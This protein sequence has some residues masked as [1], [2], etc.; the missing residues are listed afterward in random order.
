MRYKQLLALGL[1]VVMLMGTGCQSAGTEAPASTET[2]VVQE[3][4]SEALET[5]NEETSVETATETTGAESVE[6]EVVEPEEPEVLE[7]RYVK[8]KKISIHAAP[9]EESEILGELTARTE[10]EIAEEQSDESGAVKWLRLG[11]SVDPE[12]ASWIPADGVVEHKYDLMYTNY[13][14]VDYGAVREIPDYRNNPRVEVKGLYVTQHSAG[15][16]TIDKLIEI[17]DTT[18][19]NAF[20]IDMKDDN[21]NMLFKTLAAGLFC[22]EANKRAPIKDVKAFVE[23]LKEHDIYLIAR[24]VT[25][26][27]PKYA[28]RYPE[29]AIAYKGSNSLYRSG[30]NITWAS[31]HDRQL[32][33]YNIEV[34]REAAEAGFDEIQFDYVRFPATGRALD[35]KLDFKNPEEASKALTI[36]NFLK[37]AREKLTPY[38]VYISADVFGWAATNVKDVGIGHHWEALS[39]VVDYMCPMMY[40]SHYGPNNFGLSVPDAFP[41]ETIDASVKDAL[42]RDANLENPSI[43]RPWIQDFTAAWVKGHISYRAP[44][45]RAQIQ[46]LEDNGIH[47]F[48]LWNASNRYTVGGL[49]PEV[50]ETASEVENEAEQQS[51]EQVSET[52]TTED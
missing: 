49:K 29:R 45:I 13:E 46:A 1:V 43:M 22:P 23:K 44:Q 12:K 4:S 38:Q 3:T 18:E 37:Y 25:F 48:L 15:N 17:A 8:A 7:T 19:I 10:I 41:Y 31:P 51:A 14:G 20:V 2:E 21:G 47:E 35:A 33:A 27:S 36:H 30:D 34:A 40:P 6:V 42:A 28:R 16:E 39:N 26:K 32:W 24:I 52:L 50:N 11:T 5:G 9:T